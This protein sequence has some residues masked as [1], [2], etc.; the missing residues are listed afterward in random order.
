VQFSGPGADSGAAIARVETLVGHA[1]Q[2]VNFGAQAWNAVVP[3]VSLAKRFTAGWQVQQGVQRMLALA[4]GT[5]YVANYFNKPREWYSRSSDPYVAWV[6]KMLYNNGQP[7]TIG[8][9]PI[10]GADGNSNAYQALAQGLSAAI[11]MAQLVPGIGLGI[12]IGLAAQAAHDGDWSQALML[13]IGAVSSLSGCNLSPLLNAALTGVKIV[14]IGMSVYGMVDGYRNGDPMFAV[15]A[16]NIASTVASFFQSCFAAGTPIHE[17][18]TRSKSI[19]Q[20][21]SY[22][23]YGDACDRVLTRDEHNPYGPLV[24]KRVLRLF[25]QTAEVIGVQVRGRL[26]WTTAEH[27]FWASVRKW[28]AAGLLKA[29]DILVS[30]DGQLLPVEAIND[31]GELTTVYNLEVEDYHTYFVGSPEWGFSIWAHNAGR[32]YS[33]DLQGRLFPEDEAARVSQNGMILRRRAAASRL[34]EAQHEAG[35]ARQDRLLSRGEFAEG[36]G[37]GVLRRRGNLAQEQGRE[38]RVDQLQLHE[39]DTNM[40]RHVRGWLRQERRR[41]AR[42]MDPEAA[43]RT[44][45]G[46]VLAHGRTTPAREG[47][48]YSNSRLQLQA[49]NALEE[50]IRRRFMAQVGGAGNWLFGG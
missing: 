41:L 35:A 23:E 11:S 32:N 10:Y 9:A 44:P 29:G 22:E 46:Y 34:R 48:D 1:E 3:L 45:P 20:F 13:G 19:E 27:P 33:L 5:D 40:P 36:R 14:N 42:L 39:F 47:F 15:N 21:R 12:S 18:A 31:Q 30:H 50:G 24:L 25:K 17:T 7:L 16:L 49:N 38:G 2:Q 6:D 4:D 28:L 8:S 26:I 37:R 43:P